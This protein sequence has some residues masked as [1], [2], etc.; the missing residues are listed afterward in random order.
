MSTFYQYFAL[1]GLPVLL[2]VGGWIYAISTR[3]E[4][5][6]KYKQHHAK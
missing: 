5:R 1:Y 4:F 3:R 6:E 2:A